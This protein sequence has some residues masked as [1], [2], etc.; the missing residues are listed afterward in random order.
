MPGGFSDLHDRF[1]IWPSFAR[2]PRRG[3]PAYVGCGNA[4]RCLI[5]I[6]QR[7]GRY[8]V[9]P[10]FE[11]SNISS[12]SDPKP[13]PQFRLSGFQFRVSACSTFSTDRNLKLETH[14][15]AFIIASKSR[16][17]RWGSLWPRNTYPS[18]VTTRT[19]R[20]PHTYARLFP[21]PRIP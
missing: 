6:S 11:I 18:E 13:Q 3:R 20:F 4:G 14:F 8:T 12:P 17:I 19:P 15:P 21:T 1:S 9:S 5:E 7:D 10:N 2:P 16:T